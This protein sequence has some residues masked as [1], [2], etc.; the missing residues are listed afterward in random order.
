MDFCAALRLRA[1]HARHPHASSTASG[2]RRASAGRSS[3]KRASAGGAASSCRPRRCS[4]S[5]SRSTPGHMADHRSDGRRARLEAARRR[6][7]YDPRLAG[8]ARRAVR[9]RRAQGLGSRFPRR[10][11]RRPGGALARRRSPR[12]RSSAAS[13]A[14]F[15]SAIA[16]RWRARTTTSAPAR[17][18]E[19]SRAPKICCR[20]AAD[21]QHVPAGPPRGPHAA[22]ARR[23]RAARIEGGGRRTS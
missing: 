17:H 21:V 13:R 19:A 14:G 8:G 10:R 16:A 12:R 7:L 15:S 18:R 22:L 2:R 6:H 5:T 20:L 1:R 4:A 11:E 9:A 23:H 3:P